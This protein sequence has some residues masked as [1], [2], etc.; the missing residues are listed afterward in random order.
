MLGTW[1]SGRCAS[2]TP[3]TVPTALAMAVTRGGAMGRAGRPI[4]T[5]VLVGMLSYSMRCLG[6]LLAT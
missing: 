1:H 5:V 3:G 2:I 4:L 6:C